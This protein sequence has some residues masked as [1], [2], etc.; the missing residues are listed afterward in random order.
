MIISAQ[1]HGM[2][3][4]FYVIVLVVL[5]SLSAGFYWLSGIINQHQEQI[6]YWVSEKLGHQVEIH[7]A[8]LTW[9]NLAPK[10]EL[11]MVKVLAEDDVT[12]LLTVDKLYLDLDLYDSL[13]YTEL[14]L[15]DITLMG[16]RIGVVRDQFGQIALKGLN[17]QGDSTPLFAELLVR[18][19][20]LN[21]VH[22]RNITV[23]FTDQ[24]KTVLTGRYQIDNAL[25]QHQLNK[26]QANGLVQ[27]PASLGESIEFK[28]NWLL[29]EQAPERTTWQWTVAANE[30]QLA[31]LQ[32]DLIFQ[33]VKVKQGR[34]N[35]VMTGKGIG[36]RL[37]TSQLT[38]DLNQGQLTSEHEPSG[39][40]KPSVIIDQLTARLDW[41]QH[42][43]GWTLKVD[44]LQLDMN[45]NAWPISSFKIV[46]QDEQLEVIG[47]FLRIEDII[48]I[49]SLSVHLPEQIIGQKPQGELQNY[50]FV[51]EPKAG[52]NIARFQLIDGELS[53]WKE[54][55]GID[56]L[57][58]KITFEDQRAEIK[59][60]SQ[61]VTVSP[62]AWLK[63]P[64]FFDEISGEVA[65]QLQPDL[66]SWQ[67]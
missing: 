22:L 51:F 19:N 47:D 15:D 53:A 55:P 48:T 54:Y 39:L 42:K 60:A 18:S 29:N 14:R 35:A 27:L 43:T 4:P 25:I 44:E 65:I 5:L 30:V 1:Q 37:N 38:L 46:N 36:S 63:A 52:L 23:D 40:Q 61:K 32:N 56:N 45:D 26:W 31:P 3:K 58:V 66:D 67:L 49:L 62:A 10:L 8:K 33:S 28:A 21:S 17:Q 34:V 7:Q 24:Q 11:D 41:Q 64:L 16:L 13:R 57:N 20:A 12:Q 59:L 6:A 50:E 9:V 2:V